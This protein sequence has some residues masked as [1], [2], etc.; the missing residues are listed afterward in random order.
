MG[1]WQDTRDLK[2]AI[3]KNVENGR[4][5]RSLIEAVEQM[6]TDVP[7]PSAKPTRRH[8][9]TFVLSALFGAIWQSTRRR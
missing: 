6:E 9:R 8:G 4:G 7:Q 5:T 3:Q 2:V 1:F